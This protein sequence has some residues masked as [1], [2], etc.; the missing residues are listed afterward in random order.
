MLRRL[1]TRLEERPVVLT[2]G[3]AALLCVAIA[4]LD[5]ITEAELA[6]SLFYVLPVALLVWFV[7]LPAA[8]IAALAGAGISLYL[9]LHSDALFSHA[10]VPYWNA[11]TSCA[12]F[13]ATILLLR[14]LK[15]ALSEEKELARTDSLTGTANPRRFFEAAAMELS[16]SERYKHAF[17]VVY[18]D[19]DD[20]K[21]LNDRFGH[22]RGDE[23]LKGIAAAI[24]ETA[25]NSDLVARL[26]GDEF[27]VLLPE[28]S[29]DGA[30]RFLV[31]L[32]S[33]LVDALE[34][35]G[36][37]VTV[38]VGAVS[39]LDVPNS[40][41]EM[42]AAADDLMYEVKRAGKNDVRQRVVGTLSLEPPV[43]PLSPASTA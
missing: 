2:I 37:I 4:L 11:L 42:V 24:A 10:I 16:R 8:A 6:F 9:D 38:S 27:G 23:I 41:E 35:F 31:R 29:A 5:Y 21:A 1:E 30:A 12:L 25:R 39:F 14:A 26:G 7:G 43:T 22:V 13:G 36:S 32:K 28:T 18:V 40:V 17:T 19:V 33:Q 20:F 34:S 15:R 3:I